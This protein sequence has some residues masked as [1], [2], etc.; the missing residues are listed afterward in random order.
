[1]TKRG[2][3]LSPGLPATAIAAVIVGFATSVIATFV[4]LLTFEGDWGWMLL[5]F[6]VVVHAVMGVAEA[7]TVAIILGRRFGY[8]GLRF[9]SALVGATVGHVLWCVLLFALWPVAAAGEASEIILFVLAPSAAL[10]GAGAAVAA[11][12]VPARHV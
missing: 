6:L 8:L 1:M 7:I 10:G 2:R 3:R 11:A 5:F 12:L 9:V 4:F